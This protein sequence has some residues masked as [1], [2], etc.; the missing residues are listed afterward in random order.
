MRAGAAWWVAG[1]PCAVLVFGYAGSGA[2]LWASLGT[3]G[4]HALDVLGGEWAGPALAVQWLTLGGLAVLVRCQQHT[5]PHNTYILCIVIV[6]VVII[7]IIII[8][9]ITLNIELLSLI[10]NLL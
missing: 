10:L 6:V 4:V 1:L 8:I 7:I 2:V 5:R 3:L 9:I